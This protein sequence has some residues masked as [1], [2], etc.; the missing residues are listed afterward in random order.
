MKKIAK[1]LFQAYWTLLTGFEPKKEEL[2]LWRL[3][4]E[5]NLILLFS[6]LVDVTSK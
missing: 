6:D 2:L 3:T 1:S 4:T 5:K